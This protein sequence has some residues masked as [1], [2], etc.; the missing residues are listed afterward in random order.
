MFLDGNEVEE[1]DPPRPQGRRPSQQNLRPITLRPIFS[2]RPASRRPN[3]ASQRPN[4]RPRPQSVFDRLIG[5]L[6]QG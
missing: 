4:E 5:G 6:F 2:P 1:F 3:N